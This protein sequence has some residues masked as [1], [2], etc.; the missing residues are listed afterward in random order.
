ME[1]CTRRGAQM[2]PEASC[3]YE[4]VGVI[5]FKSWVDECFRTSTYILYHF[6]L[7]VGET[8]RMQYPI[9]V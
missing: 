5:V 6:D 1:S 7:N 2:T 4:G 8:G 9:A 3:M